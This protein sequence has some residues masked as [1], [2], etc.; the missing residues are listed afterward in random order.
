MSS[1]GAELPVIVRP[2]PT[3]HSLSTGPRDAG[4]PKRVQKVL[5]LQKSSNIDNPGKNDTLILCLT[6]IFQLGAV[7]MLKFPCTLSELGALVV[8]VLFFSLFFLF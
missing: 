5:V 8:K 4:E 7:G 1:L 3:Y 6:L 2:L